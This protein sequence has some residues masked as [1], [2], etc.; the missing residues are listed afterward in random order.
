MEVPTQ[1]LHLSRPR[2]P[3]VKLLVSCDGTGKEFETTR[4]SPKQRNHHAPKS[5]SAEGMYERLLSAIPSCCTDLQLLRTQT[6]LHRVY[7]L[8]CGHYTER[9]ISA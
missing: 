9:T 1:A 8:I 2:N 4:G 7:G 5:A 3:L 6:P